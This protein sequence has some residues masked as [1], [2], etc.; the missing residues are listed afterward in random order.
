MAKINQNF[1]IYAGEDKQINFE[2]TDENDDVVDLTDSNAVW[3]MVRLGKVNDYVVEK[4]VLSAIAANTLIGEDVPS[5]GI[6][7]SGNTYQVMLD[8]TDTNVLNGKY[9]HEL[10]MIKG[11][12][13]TVAAIGQVTV[14]NSLTSGAVL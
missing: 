2:I 5:G 12:D 6:V 11:T 4:R 3:V 14:Y 13:E 9:R 1:E 10:R 8:E 7:I